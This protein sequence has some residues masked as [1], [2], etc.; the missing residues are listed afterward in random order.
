MKIIKILEKI[1]KLNI[2]IK[3]MVIIKLIKSFKS[4]FKTYLNMLSQK[5]RDNNKLSN[6]Q[7]FFSNLENKKCYMK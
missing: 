6:V 5:A 1:K 7:V 3:E 4:L 2:A